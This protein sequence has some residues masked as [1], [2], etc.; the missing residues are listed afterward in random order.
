MC[1]EFKD[2]RNLSVVSSSNPRTLYNHY[3]LGTDR[4]VTRARFQL[5]CSQ[6]QTQDL[7]GP[8]R[9]GPVEL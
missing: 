5:S 3:N 1:F 9:P 4:S 2:N 7:E 6:L 8:G